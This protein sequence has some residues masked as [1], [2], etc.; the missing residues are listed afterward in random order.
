MEEFIEC[1]L[2]KQENKLWTRH[3][4]FIKK[5]EFF[6]EFLLRISRNMTNLLVTLTKF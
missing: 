5:L 6:L 4:V 1:Q 2:S 3:P